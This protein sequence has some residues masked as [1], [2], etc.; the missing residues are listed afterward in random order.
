MAVDAGDIEEEVP[1]FDIVNTSL[2]PSGDQRIGAWTW[3]PRASMRVPLPSALATA[4]P[5]ALL[6]NAIVPV[7]CGESPPHPVSPR[8][9]AATAIAMRLLLATMSTLFL[10]RSV[11]YRKREQA[12]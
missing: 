4:T 11:G 3:S 2:L 10:Q 8:P 9:K 6:M 5:P 1:P 12:V 7:S